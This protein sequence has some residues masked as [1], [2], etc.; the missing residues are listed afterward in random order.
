[1]NSA[2]TFGV[3]EEQD[4][5][6][7]LDFSQ[8]E[9]RRFLEHA[10]TPAAKY[11]RYGDRLLA[12]WL[13]QGV[14]QHFVDTHADVRID[15]DV[16]V[17]RSKIDQK[18]YRVTPDGRVINGIKASMSSSSSDTIPTSRYQTL[19]IAGKALRTT[20]RALVGEGWTS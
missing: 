17:P 2:R 1:M 8:Q 12:V 19:A 10:G 3:I 18:Y 14:A 9:L 5:Q 20:S 13:V 6:E 15:G 11:R 4:L 7:I 16:E